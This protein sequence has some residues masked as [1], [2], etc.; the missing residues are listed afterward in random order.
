MGVQLAHH[1]GVCMPVKHIQGETEMGETDRVVRVREKRKKLIQRQRKRELERDSGEGNGE[2]TD[3][4]K[5]RNGEAKS[6]V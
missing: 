6:W 1:I 3:R 4:R 5:Q 2:N